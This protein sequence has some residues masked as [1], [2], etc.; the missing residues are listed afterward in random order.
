MGFRTA[1]FALSCLAAAG[2][3]A[4]EV[5]S[6][7]VA[8]QDDSVARMVK[9]AKLKAGDVVVD[10]G[11]GDGRIVLAAARASPGVTGWGVDLDEKL[12]ARANETA[13]KEGLAQR[14]QFHQRNVFDADLSKVDVI[15]MWLFPELQ[16]LLRPKI[17]A[18]ARPGTRV[19]TNM[20]DMGTWQADDV[21]D[22]PGLP[23]RLW[24]VPAN[25]AGWWN[26]TL[27]LKGER[28]D[29]AAVLEQQFQKVEGV[30]RSADRRRVLHDFK[31]EG[32][33]LSFSLLTDVE[34]V[35]YT[36]HQFSGRVSGDTI[37][38][39]ALVYHP[40]SH[41]A[42]DYQYTEVPWRAVRETRSGYFAP[43]GLDAR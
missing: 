42:E 40:V 4:Q 19:V 17:L 43:T 9:L 25:V 21:D 34:R 22:N 41:G 20:F 10:L 3:Q 8:S 29:F 27:E 38:G 32:D 28:L 7:F 36:R 30:V 18:E 1:F 12:V 13:R 26:W 5:F 24:V 14:V 23:L 39:K 2:A 35:G 37:E 16:R 15:F 11:S 31:L 33:R 6:P